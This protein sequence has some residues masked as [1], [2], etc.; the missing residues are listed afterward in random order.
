[1]SALMSED[2]MSLNL[3]DDIVV[4]ARRT[5]VAGVEGDTTWFGQV[6]GEPLSA[7]TFVRV[8]GILQGSIRTAR[9]VFSVEPVAGGP[10]Y[11]I[12]QL[13]P[14]APLPELPPLVPPQPPSRIESFRQPDEK[15]DESD[16]FDVL[17]HERPYRES[18]TW[19]Q[20]AAEIRAGAGT[21]F[22]PE[23]VEAFVALGPE[24]WAAGSESI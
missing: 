7:V 17:V 15:V 12:R 24:R 13:N 16:V 21:H 20:A 1:V 8:D 10:D 9:G 5:K 2:T 22:D 11:L 3:F 23:V 19:E 4:E 6:D 18:F 14:S